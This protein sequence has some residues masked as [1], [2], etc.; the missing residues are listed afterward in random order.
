MRPCAR[1]AEQ[2]LP[3]LGA[4]QCVEFCGGLAAVLAAVGVDMSRAPDEDPPQQ[5][6]KPRGPVHAGDCTDR[7]ACVVAAVDCL[8][9]TCMQ[10]PAGQ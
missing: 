9:A 1:C 5:Q 8:V 10:Q 6:A 2:V 3:A 4:E 7:C